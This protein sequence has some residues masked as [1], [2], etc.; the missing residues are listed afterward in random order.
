MSSKSDTCFAGAF[1]M[2]FKII[3]C[4]IGFNIITCEEAGAI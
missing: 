4:S 1:Y 3:I 2:R